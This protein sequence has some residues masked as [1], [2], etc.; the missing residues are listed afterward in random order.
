MSTDRIVTIITLFLAGLMP[1]A[2]AGGLCVVKSCP[3]REALP[4]PSSPP[5]GQAKCA[6]VAS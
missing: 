3:Y 2:L 6:G 1:F 5:A 4:S